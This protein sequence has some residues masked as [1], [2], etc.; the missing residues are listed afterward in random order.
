MK[1]AICEDKKV[2][3]AQVE[4]YLLELKTKN[5]E[6]DVFYDGSELINY[7]ETGK[8]PYQIY[9]LDIRMP[10]ID[11]IQTAKWIRQRDQAAVI[12]FMTNYKEYVYDVFEALP[13]RFLQKPVT[14]HSLKT[15]VFD[16]MNYLYTIKK[17][18]IFTVEKEQ[19]QIAYDE[20]LYLESE[21]RKI[22]LYTRNESFEF[23]GKL[24]QIEK[25]LD[26][27]LFVRI[28]VSYLVNLEYVRKV[29]KEEAEMVHGMVLPISKKYRDMFREKQMDF[30]KW[31]N[32]I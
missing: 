9:L 23:Y 5:L 22:H 4:Q 20:I 28:H 31:R 2:A 15:A 10:H 25:A 21:L 14:R 6:C 32:G 13:F 29:T 27:N 11:G 8:E 24:N 12:I 19:Y 26:P 18:L 17:Y 7:L 1:V 3:A 16:A 30:V